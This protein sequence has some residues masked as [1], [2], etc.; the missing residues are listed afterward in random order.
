MKKGMLNCSTKHWITLPENYSHRGIF[1]KKV[2]A[3]DSNWSK[4]GGSNIWSDGENIYYSYE[5]SHYVKVGN[6]WEP[7]TW[8]GLSSF[9][10]EDVWTDGTN[11]YYSSYQTH[12]Q[13][14]IVTK[15]WEAKTWEGITY[16]Y[17]SGVWSDGADFYYSA[18]HRLVNG[19]WVTK[20][21]TG[22]S[23]LSGDCVWSDGVNIY[24]S[25]GSDQYVLNGSTWEEKVWVGQTIFRGENIWTDGT[26]LYC[27]SY[28]LVNG[29]WE[30]CDFGSL[31]AE[32]V[33]TDGTNIYGYGTVLL[34][35]KVKNVLVRKDGAWM[36]IEQATQSLITFAIDTADTY[37]SEELTTCTAREGMCWGEY[38]FSSYN[39][40]TFFNEKLKLGISGT[41]RV[42][43]DAPYHR[44]IYDGSKT[45]VLTDIIQ[46]GKTYYLTSK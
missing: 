38:I 2:V 9:K 27:G 46:P 25:S 22:L 3:D 32:S 7:T 44:Q 20:K 43:V 29:D 4:V 24:Y 23:F 31:G 36:P 33:W 13:L 11:I 15:T 39:N 30:P 37:D 35:S 16:F 10:G 1:V 41:N 21:W 18:T 40:Q 6:T 14:N 42:G 17:G 8:N 26:D 19:A 12:Y 45:T 28:K 5:N 34:P